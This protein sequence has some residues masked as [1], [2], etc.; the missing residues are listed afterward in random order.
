M[1][2][3]KILKPMKI[4]FKI[5]LFIYLRQSLD[6]AREQMDKLLKTIQQRNYMEAKE[7]GLD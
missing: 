7:K 2:L 4:F 5:I 1:R 6:S 3:I